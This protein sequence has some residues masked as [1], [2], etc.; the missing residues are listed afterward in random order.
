[1]WSHFDITTAGEVHLMD[2]HDL[3]LRGCFDILDQLSCLT[4]SGFS[5]KYEVL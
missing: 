5:V 1:M 2:V 3:S 4:E